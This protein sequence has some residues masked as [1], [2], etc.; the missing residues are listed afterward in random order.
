MVYSTLF[1][2]SIMDRILP[3]DLEGKLYFG[4]MEVVEGQ[5]GS[6]ELAEKISEIVKRK[7]L[8]L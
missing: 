6:S 4:E 1:L 5:F 7:E 2:G 8:Q 3:V